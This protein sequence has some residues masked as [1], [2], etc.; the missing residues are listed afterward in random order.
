[1]LPLN[2]ALIRSAKNGNLSHWA[3][4]GREPITLV[5]VLLT[6]LIDVCHLDAC[7]LHL[8]RP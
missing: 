6:Q 1:M 7:T 4:F 2:R 5:L 8:S 3:F